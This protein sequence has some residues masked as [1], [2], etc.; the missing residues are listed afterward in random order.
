MEAFVGSSH[1]AGVP[2]VTGSH[3]WVPHGDPGWAYLREMELLLAAGLSPMDVIVAST[4]Q[5]ARFFRVDHRLG[6][7]EPG[8]LAD[9][10]L[11]EGNPLDD[12]RAMRRVSRVM[13]NGN[14]VTPDGGG[15][16]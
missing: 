16:S 15:G 10:V 11:V 12:M 2:I 7:I 4:M 8:K 1:R 6:S 3:S 9:L 5:N 13:L 14:W